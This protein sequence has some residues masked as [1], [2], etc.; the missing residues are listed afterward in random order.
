MGVSPM[1]ADWNR[2][3]Y[4]FRTALT[5]AAETNLVFWT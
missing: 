3:A 4:L 2:R 1:R 5:K